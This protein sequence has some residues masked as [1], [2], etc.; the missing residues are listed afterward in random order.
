MKVFKEL[1][2]HI[3]EN[4]TDDF[5]HEVEINLQNGWVREKE[6]EKEFKKDLNE[7][8]YFFSNDNEL[9]NKAAVIVFAR[10]DENIIYASNVVPKKIG[11]LSTNEYNNILSDF[12]KENIQGLCEQKAIKTKLTSDTQSMDNWISPASYDKILKFSRAANK[13]TG[14]SHPLDQKRWFAFIISIVRNNENLSTDRL[15]RWLIE[16]EDWPN[17]IASNLAIEYETGIDLLKYY[18]EHSHDV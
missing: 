1:Y 6:K 15:E 8:A 7:H 2:I 3:T 13:S 17:D 5:F 14:S 9:P 4:S 11:K 12:Y 16:E 10:K 18:V